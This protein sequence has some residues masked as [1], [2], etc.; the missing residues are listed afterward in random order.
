MNRKGRVSWLALFCIF[1]ALVF[2]AVVFA[3]KE[4]LS[5]V[6]GRFMTALAKG[7]VDTLTKMTYLGTESQEDIRS[8]WDFAVNHAGKYYNFF[9]HVTGAGMADEK[10]GAVHLS[11]TRNA[12]Q[13]GSFEENYQLPM[14]KVGDEWKVDVKSI[15]RE[16]Y[17]ALPH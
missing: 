14:V 8:Q 2:V 10:S 1:A 9:Y 12:D 17:P 7:D 16:M 15:S 5:S 4:S 11:V 6:G 3:S 13:P